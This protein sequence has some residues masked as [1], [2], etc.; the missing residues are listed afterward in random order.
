MFVDTVA[1]AVRC[2]KSLSPRPVAAVLV[3]RGCCE[4]GDDGAWD[5]TLRHDGHH[6]VC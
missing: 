2:R 6:G 1:F 5:V 3:P 4:P